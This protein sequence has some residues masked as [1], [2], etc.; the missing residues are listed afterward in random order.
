MIK[1]NSIFD[2]ILNSLIVLFIVFVYAVFIIYLERKVAAYIQC[3][4]GPKEVGYN[5][6]TQSFADLLKLF[7]KKENSSFRKKNPLFFLGPLLMVI[8]VIS[9]FFALPLLNLNAMPLAFIG[10]IYILV[11]MGIQCICIF[12]SGMASGNTYASLAS[13]RVIIQTLSY[14]IALVL[15]CL[16]VIICCGEDDLY[17][18]GINENLNLIK[19]SHFIIN[20]GF[21]KWNL[22][23][24]PSLIIVYIIY[25]ITSLS[26][27]HRAPFDLPEAGS[28]L[29]SGYYTEYSGIFVAW[30]M[31]SEY[32]LMLILSIVGV[33]LFLGGGDGILPNIGMLKLFDWT[34]V[35]NSPL[36]AKVWIVIWMTVKVFLIIFMQIAIRWSVPRIRFDQ[37]IVLYWKFLTPISM[38][39]F[40]LLSLRSCE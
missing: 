3:R 38:A 36:L 30:I 32:C 33:V 1:T 5:G 16:C 23:K 9:A 25:F 39:L 15:C 13:M 31:L 28:E 10:I 40:L 22:Y 14:K 35:P 17:K 7:Q 4:I 6:L 24:Y 12:M 18:I 29:V 26:A 21:F 37:I 20:G 19:S 2:Y 11:I 34:T 8:S 27:A